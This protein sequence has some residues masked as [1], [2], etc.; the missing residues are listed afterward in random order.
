MGSK[1]SG[2]W[3]P[4]KV[5]TFRAQFYEFLNYVS[6]NSKENGNIV[7]GEHLYPAQTRF[8]D[9]VFEGLAEDKHDIKHLKSRQL[10]VSTITRALSLF[11]LGVHSGLK[12]Y[13]VMDT[14]QHKEEA[15]LEILGMIDMLPA[16]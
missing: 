6:I 2:A 12:G 9:Q 14:D 10:G 3:N 15:R 7:L 11:W 4:Q 8:L 13:M 16:R 1:V 5:S